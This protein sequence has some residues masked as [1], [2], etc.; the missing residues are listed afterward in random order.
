MEYGSI[1]KR[2]KS[3]L[4]LTYH[5]LELVPRTER[6]HGDAL[7][8]SKQPGQIKENSEMGLSEHLPK[9]AANWQSAVMAHLPR[10]RT[11][12]QIYNLCTLEILGMHCLLPCPSFMEKLH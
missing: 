6:E 1:F 3:L 5:I 11:I 4:H 2:Y 9:Q 8:S 7:I 10:T 12:L